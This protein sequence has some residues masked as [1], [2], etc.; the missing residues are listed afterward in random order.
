MDLE[1]RTA[2]SNICVARASRTQRS[3]DRSIASPARSHGKATS[4]Q[5]SAPWKPPLPRALPMCRRCNAMR[6]CARWR[7]N[8]D[9]KSWFVRWAVARSA[10]ALRKDPRRNSRA[11]W[12]RWESNPK[13]SDTLTLS[14]HSVFRVSLSNACNPTSYSRTLKYPGILLLALRSGHYVVTEHFGLGHEG[15]GIRAGVAARWRSRAGRTPSEA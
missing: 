11:E 1:I 12:R 10:S 2:P 3:G 14:G 7:R 9:F 15:N 5:R 13:R 8:P 6:A 4:R